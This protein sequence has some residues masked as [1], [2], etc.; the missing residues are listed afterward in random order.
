MLTAVV[1]WGLVAGAFAF[2]YYA[3]HVEPWR[4]GLTRM[5]LSLPQLPEALEGL[6][7]LHLSDL[8]V[9]DEQEGFGAQVARKAVALCADL[10]PDLVCVTGDI[11]Q[12]SRAVVIAR[13][14]LRPLAVRPLLVVMG[15]HDHDKMLETQGKTRQAGSLSVQ[16]WHECMGAIGALVLHNTHTA[17]SLRGR[18]LA[19][20]GVGDPSCGFDDLPRALQ[21]APQGD[22]N[23]LL[24]H[25][26]DMVD[27]PRTDW[28]DLMLCGHTHGGQLRLPGLGTPWA[29]VWHDRHRA[30]GLMQFGR[31]LL[32]V[33]RGVGAGF[34]SRF[35]CPPEVVL[36]TFTRG[37]GD[38]PR[39][40]QRR[41]HAVMDD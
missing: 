31:T 13:E 32:F 24:V 30:A 41:P 4:V 7:L 21:H 27:D 8:H 38:E 26:P 10:E 23:L 3:H 28:A 22:L 14:I 11:A 17:L 36:F 18:T 40:M 34:R 9:G 25:S 6:Q 16:E 29:P 12:T 37:E 20:A 1:L 2:Y 19:V 5:T 35:L 39:I 15:N 33:T